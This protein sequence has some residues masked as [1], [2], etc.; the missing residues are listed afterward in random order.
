M[1]SQRQQ[2]AMR[3]LTHSLLQMEAMLCKEMCG[4]PV[5][6]K[7]LPPMFFSDN[8]PFKCHYRLTS[9]PNNGQSS[10]V[11]NTLYKNGTFICNE[12]INRMSSD[13]QCLP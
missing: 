3:R 5:S 11:L 6:A 4:A 2:C 8:S 12:K 13:L 1:R 9:R 10:L 7:A